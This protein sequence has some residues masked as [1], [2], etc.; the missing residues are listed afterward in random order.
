MGQSFSRRSW[1]V[2]VGFLMVG[3]GLWGCG[4][5]GS[6]ERREDAS[7]G[8]ET[9]VPAPLPDLGPA[10]ELQNEIWLNSDEPVTLASLRG[11]VVLLEF[12]TFG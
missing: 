8:M 11:N 7:G 12:W 3:I 5:P 1:V 9:A 6:P 2:M 4:V 10:P